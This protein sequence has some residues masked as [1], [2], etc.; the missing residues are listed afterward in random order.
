MSVV[1]LFIQATEQ[2]SGPA[3][4]L[5]WVGTFWYSAAVGLAD[6]C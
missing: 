6:W 4:E 5:G 3:P 2:P 1:V